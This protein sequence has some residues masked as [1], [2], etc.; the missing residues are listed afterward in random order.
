MWYSSLRTKSEFSALT[1]QNHEDILRIISLSFLWV[2]SEIGIVWFLA[3]LTFSVTSFL[4]FKNVWRLA[5]SLLW[6]RSS[7][8]WFCHHH[9]EISRQLWLSNY[10][11]RAW[12][13]CINLDE[14]T[15]NLAH[16]YIRCCPVLSDETLSLSIFF[17]QEVFHDVAQEEYLYKYR[18]KQSN[19]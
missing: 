5:S 7:P 4:A 13:V 17:A 6:E 9:F 2:W 18:R 12:I 3:V 10:L 19:K 8:L 15:R 1:S 16:M 14:A 11:G